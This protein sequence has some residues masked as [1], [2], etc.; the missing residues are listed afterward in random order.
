MHRI[1]S[2]RG[3]LGFWAGA[4][5]KLMVIGFPVFH[6]LCYQTLTIAA[7]D[8]MWNCRFAYRIE[9]KAELW[10]KLFVF[11]GFAA[12]VSLQL[13]QQIS[14][15]RFQMSMGWLRLIQNVQNIPGS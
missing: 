6:S 10:S 5:R 14:G 15:S 13:T 7:A 1:C 8:I 3:L 9:L 4:L 2:H 12:P 11:A